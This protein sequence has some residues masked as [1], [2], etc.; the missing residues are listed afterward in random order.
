MPSAGPPY[1]V[2]HLPHASTFIPP[3]AARAYVLG[4]EDV[5]REVI[6]MTDR[7]T[8]DLFR[9]PG[10]EAASVEFPVCRLVVDP[11]RFVDDD[12]EPMAAHGLGVIYTRTADGRPL[13]PTPTPAEREVLLNRY[14]VP[15]HAALAAAVA[16]CLEEWGSCLVVDCHSFPAAPLP[17]EAFQDPARPDICLGTDPY[18][19]PDWL[20][21]AAVAAFEAEGYSVEVNRP[22]SGALVPMT[23]YGADPSV[24]A[25]MV[26]VNRGLFMD[27]ETGARGPD[28]DLHAARVQRAVR[29]VAAHSFGRA[30]IT[31]P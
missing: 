19:T 12:Q 31:K 5:E 24:L 6:R 30:P 9:F 11:E 13:R 29:A 25:V 18:H 3:D 10:A 22:F 7:Y 20:R 14:Y 16:A 8:D 26:E 15:H 1:L 21:E 4:A 2:L 17:Y 27:E 28:L 23:Y